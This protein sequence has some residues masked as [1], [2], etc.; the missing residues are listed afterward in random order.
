MTHDA[1]DEER[2]ERIS[3]EI[4]VDAYGPEEQAIRMESKQPLTR[5][6][7][8]RCLTR[9]ALTAFSVLLGTTNAGEPSF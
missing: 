7:G 6:G 4:I 1:S 2:E 8:V 3:M 5:R 9:P